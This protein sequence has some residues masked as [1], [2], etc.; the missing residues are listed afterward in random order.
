MEEAVLHFLTRHD[1]TV[2]PPSPPKTKKKPGA[3]I[4]IVFQ[5]NNMSVFLFFTFLR[6]Q[7]LILLAGWFGLVRSATT[8]CSAF[9]NLSSLR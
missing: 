4:D 9:A 1:K 5:D 8:T 7:G 3:Q 2:P 6:K